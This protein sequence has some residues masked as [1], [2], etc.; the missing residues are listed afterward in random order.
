[1]H[2]TEPG[3]AGEGKGRNPKGWGAGQGRRP[4]VKGQGYSRV[5]GEGGRVGQREEGGQWPQAGENG[6]QRGSAHPAA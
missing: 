6:G 4:R 1:M 2:W 5:D 3:H